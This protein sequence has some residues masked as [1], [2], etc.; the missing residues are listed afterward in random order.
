MCHWR[1]QRNEQ[2][3]RCRP[4]NGKQQNAHCRPE[5]AGPGAGSME[6]GFCAERAL[7]AKERCDIAVLHSISS[8]SVWQ[9]AHRRS[10][11]A[12]SVASTLGDRFE[13]FR[14]SRGKALLARSEER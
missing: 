11:L 10:H 9:L 7:P 5:T 12:T 1:L 13:Q 8:T 6:A 3:R 2:K 14:A 4:F